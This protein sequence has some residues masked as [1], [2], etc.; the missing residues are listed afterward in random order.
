M[1]LEI[2]KRIKLY[3]I[4]LI[5]KIRKR[6]QTKFQFAFIT[7][8]DYRWRLFWRATGVARTHTRVISRVRRHLLR[9]TPW[10][11]TLRQVCCSFE[12]YEIGCA[13]PLTGSAARRRDEFLHPL[14]T[15][16]F[17]PP[18]S[19][20]CA[21][22]CTPFFFNFL[23]KDDLRIRINIRTDFSFFVEPVSTVR[24]IATNSRMSF[25]SSIVAFEQINGI[26]NGLDVPL[27]SVNTTTPILRDKIE[28][29]LD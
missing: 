10:H 8:G 26:T 4:R 19:F 9:S 24:L 28:E 27:N 1:Q 2:K 17:F 6:W 25:S 13:S 12:V 20:V 23:V 3:F 22:L 11:F 5:A 18:S 21:C 29:C 7:N 15:T 14:F 16:F